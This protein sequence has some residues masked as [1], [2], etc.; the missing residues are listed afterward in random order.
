MPVQLYV[1]SGFLGSGK[2][3]LINRILETAPAHLKIMVLVN[4]FG[5]I[6]IDKKIINIDPENIIDLSGG[7]IC[8]GLFSELM[9]SLRFALDD[10]NAAMIL[11]ES[12]GLAL[13]QEIARQAL[14]PAFKKTITLGAIITVVDAAGTQWD[15]YPI[16]AEQL[17]ASDIVILNKTDLVDATVLGR[18]RNKIQHIMPPGSTLIETRFCRIDYNEICHPNSEYIHLHSSH[19]ESIQQ[20]FDSTAGYTAISFV[21]HQTTPLQTLMQLYDDWGK[22]IIRSKGFLLTEKGSMELQFSQSGIQIK[23]A[24]ESIDRTE[25]VLIVRDQDRKE[26][27]DKFRNTFNG[28]ARSNPRPL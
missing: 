17:K 26:I 9:A 27:E 6:S 10:F 5:T 11:I 4:E 14:I 22:K 7:C 25:I 28:V 3:T 15:D 23:N 13:P 18:V 24:G 2:T 1:V 12:T 16:I 20:K 8:C 19:V 21:F